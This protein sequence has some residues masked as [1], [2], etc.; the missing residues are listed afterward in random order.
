[1]ENPFRI[2]LKKLNTKFRND[3]L[4]FVVLTEKIVPI[5]AIKMGK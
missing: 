1:M 4:F 3:G 5:N 2:M